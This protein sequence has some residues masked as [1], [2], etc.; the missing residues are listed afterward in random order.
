[1]QWVKNNSMLSILAH[2]LFIAAS[3]LAIFPLL[4]IIIGSFKDAVELFRSGVNLK[5]T[6]ELFTWDNYKNLF[7]EG[8]IY[9]RWFWNS[10]VVTFLYTVISVFLSGMVGY[11]LGVYKFKGRNIIFS[12]VLF[13]M[14][15]PVEILL[16]P[17]YKL[18]IF[19]NII[20]T[21]WGVILPFAV[22]PFVVFFFRQ[23][24]IGLPKDFLDSARVDGCSEF[25][26][27]FKI[28]APMMVPAFGAMSIMQAMFSW[29]NFLWPLIV[30]RTDDM[31]TL[32]IGLAS[33][34]SPY[35][36]N[37]SILLAGSTLMVIPILIIFLF[38]Q[39]YF[40]SGLT[41][42]GIKG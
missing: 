24:A 37:Y 42:G 30:L 3:F 29:N 33:L 34:M 10:I 4:V 23:F 17:L 14:M 6:P 22:T 31:F 26:I 41:T 9:F 40:I 27:F 16:L 19:L 32:P 8:T 1:M 11:G 38:F 13:L 21:Y 15:I 12:L 36:N 35:G 25:G 28:M 18:S 5:L 7:T 39:R 2:L 20:N